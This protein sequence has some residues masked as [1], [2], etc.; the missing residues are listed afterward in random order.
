MY[1]TMYRTLYVASF[2]KVLHIYIP[3]MVETKG[4]ESSKHIKRLA[5]YLEQHSMPC[6]W[7]SPTCA[8]LSTNIDTK[9]EERENRTD[10]AHATFSVSSRLGRS[11][12]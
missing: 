8:N 6:P 11:P 9:Q 4:K 1:Y 7:P 5:D 10:L 3:T 12:P 2:A